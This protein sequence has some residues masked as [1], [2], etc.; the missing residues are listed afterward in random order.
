MEDLGFPVK[1][2]ASEPKPLQGVYEL[3][4]SDADAKVEIAELFGIEK[5]KALFSALATI[6]L[7]GLVIKL[8][9]QRQDGIIDLVN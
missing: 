4:R 2:F 6:S 3:V 5:F 7:H 9:Q 1:N 8:H